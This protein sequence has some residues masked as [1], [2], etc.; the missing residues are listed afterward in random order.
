M[1]LAFYSGKWEKRTETGQK[2][3]KS[4][5]KLMPNEWNYELNG[6][7]R[8]E[9]KTFLK[10]SGEKIMTNAPEEELNS[11]FLLLMVT[12]EQLKEDS[13]SPSVKRA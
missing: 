10:R 9:V 6:G 11:L 4:N 1:G 2:K 13:V 5:G 3:K 12:E 8:K 7:K